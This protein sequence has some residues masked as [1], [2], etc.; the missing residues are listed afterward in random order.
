MCSSDL[1]PSHDS[2]VCYE[3]Y[4]PDIYINTKAEPYKKFKKVEK[5]TEVINADE[6][7][8]IRNILT[9]LSNKGDAFVTGERN[10]FIFK[11]ACD[12]NT[13][14]VGRARAQP[15]VRYWL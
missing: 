6:D 4:D 7:K 3:S 12:V 9:W 13:V 2:R 14:P 8:T 1:F 5:V 15:Y 10:L 11:F